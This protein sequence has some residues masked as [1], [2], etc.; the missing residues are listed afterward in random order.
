MVRVCLRWGV[1]ALK[2]L[3]PGCTGM[4]LIHRWRECCVN[5][6]WEDYRTF[7]SMSCPWTLYDL[8]CWCYGLIHHPSGTNF[9]GVSCGHQRSHGLEQVR[10]RYSENVSYPCTSL[11]LGSDPLLACLRM[12]IVVVCLVRLCQRW[13]VVVLK[14]LTPGCTGVRLIHQWS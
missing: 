1:V 3:I 14:E 4:R 11:L 10:V 2:E 6:D 5:D 7:K 8:A 13:S 9:V 12:G